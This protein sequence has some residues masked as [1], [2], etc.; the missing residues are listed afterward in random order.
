M[1]RLKYVRCIA[2]ETERA[3]DPI[4]WEQTTDF[5]C[6]LMLA[7]YFKRHPQLGT[8]GAEGKPSKKGRTMEPAWAFY[9]RSKDDQELSI[10]DQR[11]KCEEKA[12]EKGCVI[13]LEFQSDVGFSSGLSIEH[14][15]EFLRMV[16]VAE[17]RKHGVRYLFIHDVS[18]F[19]RIRA[20]S[21]IFWEERL[22]RAGIR[23]IYV[24][25]KFGDD[26]SFGTQLHRFVSHDKAHEY[27]MRLRAD[28]IRGSKSHAAL[29]HSNGGGPAYGYDRLLV[30][31]EGKVLQVMKPGQRKAQKTDRIIRTPGA[32][33]KRETVLWMF[34]SRDSG[35]GLI[36]IAAELNRRKVPS[37]RGKTWGKG[38]VR[39]ILLNTV[40]IGT[41][42]Y[43]KHDYHDRSEID[44]MPRRQIRKREE[45]V[46][47][48]NAHPP[49]VPRDLF[50]RVQN[51][52]R[53]Y[54]PRDG[55][56]YDSPHILST[57]IDCAH[58]GRRYCGQ[59]H[60]HKGKK[61][62]YYECGSY[63][64][65][66]TAVCQSY[67]IKADVLEDFAWA[68][69]A[70]RMAARPSRQALREKL[71]AMVTALRGGGAEDRLE[72]LSAVV[73][74]L[75][76]KISN[77]I[78]A[79]AERPD[80][81]ALGTALD[82]LELEKRRIERD[83]AQV[84]AQLPDESFDIE[85]AVDEMLESLDHVSKLLETGT[86][87]EKKAILRT[88]IDRVTIHRDE[89]EARFHFLKLPG[90]PI[91]FSGLAVRE[92]VPTQLLPSTEGGKRIAGPQGPANVPNQIGCGGWI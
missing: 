20:P 21:K 4:A 89:S 65:K 81:P 10:P 34:Q 19:G 55:R 32:P 62:R 80:S 91:D 79:M 11:K 39:E 45:W 73:A 9:R 2:V 36:S 5:L 33:E 84:R 41:H 24:E 31:A 58:C 12:A 54:K 74:S 48:E 86:V 43:N 29:G 16:R 13:S 38:T 49:L 67:A 83:L 90:L 35:N 28:T 88:F 17:G 26:D 64:A 57:L 22:R 27:S 68:E 50:D 23:I 1:S 76:V 52:F 40:Y 60:H 47:K 78:A 69:V 77:I 53:T 3:V 7:E 51:T 87:S 71:S 92:E 70:K 25:E 15:R 37:P 59:Y 18:R 66:G 44:E 61:S 46:V 56:R 8:P 72:Q 63:N 14:D 30:D 42:T 75:E 82:A 6:R 85:R